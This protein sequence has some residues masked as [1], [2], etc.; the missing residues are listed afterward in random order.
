MTDAVD[1]A[2]V[3]GGA[4]GFGAATARLLA[5]GG[6]RVAI[7]DLDVRAAAEVADEIVAAGAVA[8][9]YECDVA[10]EAQVNDVITRV[11]GDLGEVQALFNNA[12]ITGG[13]ENWGFIDSAAARRV[14]DVNIL[15]SIHVLN[16]VVPSMRRRGS[17]AVVNT[18]S[19][20]SFKGY[21]NSATA[22]IASK[23]AV[24]GLTKEAAVQLAPEGIRVNAVAPGVADTPL[25]HKVHAERNPEDPDAVRRAI[26]A[27]IPDRRYAS[28]EDVARV[29]EFLLNPINVHVTGAVVSVDGGEVAS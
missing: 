3:T 7:L 26:A 11:V 18:A 24:L 22:Y 27:T 13:L 21:G 28:A 19:T 9:P 10:D 6:W 23:H 29:V 17:G 25:M 14:F 8:R 5:R 4:S 16:A 15:G 20:A 2:V 1:V 12:G